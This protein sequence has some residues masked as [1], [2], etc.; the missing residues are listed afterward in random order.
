MTDSQAAEAALSGWEERIRAAWRDSRALAVGL[1]SPSGAPRYLNAGMAHL[2]SAAPAD[3]PSADAFVNPAFDDLAAGPP[4]DHPV[5]TGIMTFGDRK[6]V[7]RTVAARV[8][9]GPED[10]L[11]TGE[12]DAEELDRL[13]R[14]LT[15]YNREVNNLQRQLI[16]EKRRLEET[17]AE[18]KETQVMLIQSEKMNALG[19][20][21][22][23]VAHEINNPLAY[24]AGNVHS[25]KTAFTDIADGY[26]RLEALIDVTGDPALSQKKTEIRE[27]CDIDF[28]FGDIED[29]HNATVGGLD[30]VKKIVTDLRNFSR[31][32]EAGR[33]RV[34][35]LENVRSTL[36]LAAPDLRKRG[37]EVSVAVDPAVELECY[38][39]LLNQVFLNLIVNAAQAM[40]SGGDLTIEGES[41]GERVHLRFADS[42]PGIPPKD[43]ESIFNPFF[44]TKPVG[45][46][47]GLGLS[48][49][50]KIVRDKHGGEI[51][52]A[53]EPGNGAVFTLDLPVEL[54]A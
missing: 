8:W 47:T 18:L 16:K 27:D 53:S 38:P 49:A 37:I 36:A 10:L 32:D 43:L 45:Q 40:D 23:G 33:K 30:R 50:Y 15:D 51:R 1:F 4:S 41:S 11:V 26:G 12:F 13:N 20:L 28:L 22:A 35:L 2:L 3:G 19:Q 44:T 39:A 9:R 34:N 48:I 6:A 7:S 17:L 14:Q 52:A 42:G 24:V 54:K 46:G 5:F 29:L 21:V 31:L 25:L